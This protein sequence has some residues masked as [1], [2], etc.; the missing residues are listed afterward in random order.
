MRGEDE[1]CL[2]SGMDDYIAKPVSLDR[3]RLTLDRIAAREVAVS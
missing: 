3:L 2:S 1:R